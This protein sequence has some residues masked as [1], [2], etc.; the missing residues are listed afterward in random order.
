MDH[1]V[2][3]YY[4]LLKYGRRAIASSG[5]LPH[6][7]FLVLVALLYLRCFVT[8]N[9]LSLSLSLS[10]SLYCLLNEAFIFQRQIRDFYHGELDKCLLG[11]CDNDRQPEVAK[12]ASKIAV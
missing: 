11:D 2:K 7:Q 4:I 3:L 8:N 6:C 10:L 1:L 5:S 12:L 9:V